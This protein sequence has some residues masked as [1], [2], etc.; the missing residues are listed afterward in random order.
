MPNSNSSRATI[1]S[2][3]VN[4]LRTCGCYARGQTVRHHFHQTSK[5]KKALQGTLGMLRGRWRKRTAARLPP[6][7]HVDGTEPPLL[8]R[9]RAPIQKVREESQKKNRVRLAP[10]P[11]ETAENE[12]CYLQDGSPSPAVLTTGLVVLMPIPHE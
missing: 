3:S 6:R 12:W 2:T 7:D 1:A 4:P 9:Q 8:I 5:Q 11:V 10:D